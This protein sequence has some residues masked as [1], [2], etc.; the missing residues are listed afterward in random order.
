MSGQ[1]VITFPQFAA[2][3]PQL[4]SGV[5]GLIKGLK[6]GDTTDKTKPVGLGKCLQDCARANPE[7]TAIAFEGRE[8]SYRQFDEWTNRIAHCLQSAGIR[9]GDAVAVMIEN[10]PELLAVIT[11]CA[12]IGAVRSMVMPT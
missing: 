4:V 6:V 3:I 7:G 10:R 1:D 2:K 8:I 11:G 5:T 9:K 12:K